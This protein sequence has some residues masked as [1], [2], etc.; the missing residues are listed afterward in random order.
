LDG[1]AVR[2]RHEIARRAV[3]S[4]LAPMRRRHIHELLLG[5][6]TASGA[7]A[8]TLAHHAQGAGDTEV[9]LTHARRA[10]LRAAGMGAHREAAAHL[11]AVLDHDKD[12]TP[13]ERGELLD[14]LCFECYLTGDN[15]A[16]VA[17]REESLRC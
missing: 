12:A 5:L 6:L 7:D 14:R 16:A 9:F 13:R 2:F 8:A 10:A 17:A 4:S 15:D 1:H 3:E 11:V